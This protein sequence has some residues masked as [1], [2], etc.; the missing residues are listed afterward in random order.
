M[1]KFNV[2]LREKQIDWLDDMDGREHFF[3]DL[4][5]YLIYVGKE[6]KQTCSCAATAA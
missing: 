6:I 3:R 1:E 2:E 4:P 5:K